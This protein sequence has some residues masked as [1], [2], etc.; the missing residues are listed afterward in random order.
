MAKTAGL[1]RQEKT[2]APIILKFIEDPEYRRDFNER[3]AN[4]LQNG[5]LPA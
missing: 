5:E 1:N 4:T 3:L 2:A